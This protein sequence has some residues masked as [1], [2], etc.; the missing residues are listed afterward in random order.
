LKTYLLKK[1]YIKLILNLLISLDHHN[2][3]LKRTLRPIIREIITDVLVGVSII[4]TRNHTERYQVQTLKM[5]PRDNTIT[6]KKLKIV[7]VERGFDL[8]KSPFKGFNRDIL[9]G[10]N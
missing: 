6:I 2:S 10:T 9:D 3:L 1:V 7:G 4:N 8:M 5:N